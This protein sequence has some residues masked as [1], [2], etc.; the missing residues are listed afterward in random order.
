[1]LEA[2]RIATVN[3]PMSMVKGCGI[4]KSAMYTY[5]HVEN[6]AIGLLLAGRNLIVINKESEK[7]LER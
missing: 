7:P 5:L 3:V 4:R 1:M 6:I 2:P